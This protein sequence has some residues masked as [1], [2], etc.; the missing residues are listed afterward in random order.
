MQNISLKNE[1]LGAHPSCS[2]TL[3]ELLKLLS[4]EKEKIFVVVVVRF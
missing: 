2:E 3:G 4:E 1:S